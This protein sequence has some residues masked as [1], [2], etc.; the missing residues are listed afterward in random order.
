MIKLM[1]MKIFI[2]NRSRE[3]FMIFKIQISNN[4]SFKKQKI[5]KF[6]LEDCQDNM[7]C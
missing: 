3:E 6:K 2:H 1:S 7:I 4:L 5:K